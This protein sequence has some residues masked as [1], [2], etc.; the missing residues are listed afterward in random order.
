MTISTH[1]PRVAAET[2]DVRPATGPQPRRR[3]RLLLLAPVL[4]LLLAACQP[5]PQQESVRGLVNESRGAHGVPSLGDDVVVRYKAQQ[6]AEHLADAGRLSH[7]SLSRG[8]DGVAWVAVAENVGRG[9]SIRDVHEQFM[10]SSSHRANIL[11]RRWDRIG[12]GHAVG[13]DGYTYTVHVFVDL[14]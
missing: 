7:S 1:A 12:T 5:S 4:A 9:P 14:G 2:R 13:S 10:R 3:R 8:L 6:W 11:D